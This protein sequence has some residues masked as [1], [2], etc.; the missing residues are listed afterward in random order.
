MSRSLYARLH[1]RFGA[2]P[3]GL[4]LARAV[5]ARVDAFRTKFGFPLVRKPAAT[6]PRVAVIGGGF[7]GTSAGW[8]LAQLGATVTLYEASDRLGG[9][10]W[11][12]PDFTSERTIEWGGEL[13]GYNHP[14]WILLAEFAQLG[15][16]MLTTEDAYDS[17][18]LSMPM[19]PTRRWAPW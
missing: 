10:V 7:A 14:A 11:S 2:R 12:Q 16:S 15:L 13:I 8:M 4:A 17:L 5:R 19:V 9:R 1:R 18:G 3:T 6:G